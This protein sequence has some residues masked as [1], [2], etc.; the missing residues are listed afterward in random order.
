MRRT[1]TLLILPLLLAPSACLTKIEVPDGIYSAC[2]ALGSTGWS[3]HIET[4][5]TAHNRPLTKRNLVVEGKVTL[6]GPGYAVSLDL[7][8]LERLQP[9]VQQVIVRTTGEG[10]GAPTTQ[11]VRGV[12]PARKHQAAIRVRCGDGTLAVIHQVTGPT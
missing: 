7:G 2:H 8:P 3:A 12:F 11:S 10:V 9:R 5:Q 4:Y 1:A 6:P